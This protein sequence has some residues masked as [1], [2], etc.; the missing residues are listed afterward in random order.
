MIGTVVFRIV[1]LTAATTVAATVAA[2]NKNTPITIEACPGAHVDPSGK[3]CQVRQFSDPKSFV[4]PDGYVLH[5]PASEV[6]ERKQRADATLL[7]EQS[8][9]VSPIHNCERGYQFVAFS[10]CRRIIH[11][12]PTTYCPK[13]FKLDGSSCLKLFHTD[14]PLICPVGTTSFK[15]KSCRQVIISAP[16]LECPKGFSLRRQDGICLMEESTEATVECQKGLKLTSDQSACVSETDVVPAEF[17][18]PE[19]TAQRGR[20]CVKREVERPVSLCQHDL[21]GAA[22]P[23]PDLRTGCLQVIREEPEYHCPKGFQI[24]GDLCSRRIQ[25]QAALSCPSGSRK[26]GSRCIMRKVMPPGRQCPVGFSLQEDTCYRRATLASTFSCTNGYHVVGGN[27]EKIFEIEEKR[28]CPT[29]SELTNRNICE[30]VDTT[31]TIPICAEWG[32]IRAPPSTFDDKDT[33]SSNGPPTQ[34]NWASDCFVKPHRPPVFSCRTGQR[35]ENNRCVVTEVVQPSRDC[36]QGK[37]IGK[38]QCEVSREILPARS[39]PKNFVARGENCEI[40]EVQQARVSCPFDFEF[41]G[42][43]CSRKHSKMSSQ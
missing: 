3:G 22:G 19:G 11:S 38:Y 10:I 18:C 8:R 39:C 5:H 25:S 20:G 12:T 41:D 23:A 2:Q 36:I 29:G 28:E 14:A 21:I 9:T 31:P 42:R 37:R 35:L 1:C 30:G 4:C 15:P 33:K 26:E 40:L 13:G 7:C 32:P 27:C 43:Q 34:L 6:K 16:L 17:I 24:L